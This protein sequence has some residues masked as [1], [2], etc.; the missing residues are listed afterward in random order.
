MEEENYREC[1]LVDNKNTVNHYSVWILHVFTNM[2]GL[3]TRKE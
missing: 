2:N 3:I 1:V